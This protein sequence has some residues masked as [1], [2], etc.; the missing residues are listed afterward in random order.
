MNFNI[1]NSG[2]DG[3]GLIIEDTILKDTKNIMSCSVVNEKNGNLICHVEFQPFKKTSDKSIIKS[4]ISRIENE[5]SDEIKNKLFFRLRDNIES[6]PL[7]P[8]G[9]RRLST[10]RR[11]GIDEKTLSFEEIKEK[12]L[13][14]EE[15]KTLTLKG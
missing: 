3:N 13:Y 12:Y 9:K 2:S 11:V 5:Y 14:E 8:S 6:F 10:L 1:L 7:D 15:T 4:I